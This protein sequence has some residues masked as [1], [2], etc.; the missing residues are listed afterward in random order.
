Q[1]SETYGNARFQSDLL[2]SMT[3]GA[4]DVLE[5]RSFPAHDT[6]KSNNRVVLLRYSSSLSSYGDFEGARNTN[7]ADLFLIFQCALGPL[8]QSIHN[9]GVIFAGDDSESIQ[10]YFPLKFGSRFSRNAFIPSFMSSVAQHKPNRVASNS[11][12]RGVASK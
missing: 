11:I 8:D 2:E 10:D 5:M 12:A 6:A 4:A 7:H 9:N 3:D 1:H